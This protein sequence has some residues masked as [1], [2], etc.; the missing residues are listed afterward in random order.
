MPLPDL[1]NQNIQDTYQRVL[2][3]DASG[4]IRDGT[5]SLYIPPSASHATTASYAV[6]ASHEITYELSSSYAQTASNATNFTAS[7]NISASGH[8]QAATG[9]FNRLQ[10]SF[11]NDDTDFIIANNQNSVSLKMNN[12]ENV[13]FKN[14]E[15]T[16]FQPIT[17][18]GEISA[19][20]VIYG[21]A[22][23][24]K[25]K[26]IGTSDSDRVTLGNAGFPTFIQGNIT[27]S[28][29]ISASDI[30]GRTGSFDYLESDR[31]IG[32][33][34]D[35][36]TGIQFAPDTTII[37]SNN[38]QV[39]K[40]RA[41]DGTIIGNKDYST[42][43]SGSTF[44]VNSAQQTFIGNLTSSGHLL[45]KDPDTQGGDG[46]AILRTTGD[47]NAGT[48]IIQLGD[49]E[50]NG[51]NTMVSIDDA[52]NKV[53]V[54]NN[55]SAS[56][57]ITGEGLVISDDANI[58][59]NLTV[60]GNITSSGNISASS[61]ITDG[62]ITASRNIS[63][64]GF[65]AGNSFR[66]NGRIYT[67]YNL[68]DEHF[69][70]NTT[71]H[72]P[73][74]SAVGGFHTTGHLTASGAISSSAASTSSFGAIQMNDNKSIFF[75]NAQDLA[76]YHDGANSY[77][78]ESGTGRLHLQGGGG[79]DIIS[80]ADE[81]MGLFNANGSVELY[82]DNSKKFETTTGGIDITGN[83]TASG[84]ITGSNTGSFSHVRAHGG[85]SLDDGK[86]I[87][88]ANSPNTKIYLSNDD[89]WIITGNGVNVAQFGNGELC[90]NEGGHTTD[91]RVE[92]DNDQYQI[93]SDGGTEKVG[94]GTPTPQEK[95]TV[96]G[97]ISASGAI[98]TLSH[99]TASGVISASGNIFGGEK[100]YTNN[101]EALYATSATN[102]S[103]GWGYQHPNDTIDIGRNSG[104]V[105]ITLNG[106][107]SASGNI[108]SLGNI[109]SSG[110]I[111]ASFPDT[112]VDALHYP[113]V[114][115]ATKGV[116][117]TQNSLNINPA[118]STLSVANTV[119][120]SLGLHTH[121]F[122]GNITASGHISS[123]GNYIGRREFR[124]PN[125]AVDNTLAQGDIVYFG[126]EG[127]IAAGDIV[128]MKDD[129]TW[130]KSDAD[131]VAR[132]T[133]LHG[134]ALGADASVH[135]VLLRGTY[136][137]DHDLGNGNTGGPLYLSGT[138]G[139]LTATAP[140][141][142]VVRVM[143]YQLGDEDEIWFCPD[144]T[145]VELS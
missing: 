100:L 11:N 69:I 106:N 92:S 70:R 97:N 15:T 145:W 95:F 43:I 39:A 142:G 114:T 52:Q 138:E 32:H 60:G 93:F 42:S 122:T 123:S 67:N 71:V 77:I 38:V 128:Y 26:M 1:T 88:A 12:I 56:G 94:I 31:I 35:A 20:D 48:F 36:N 8:I 33:T 6:S 81:S 59:D 87:H 62:H 113:L 136:T 44:E 10:L 50:A 125:E 13:N 82:H 75:G 66:G 17:A 134:I 135:G 41:T 21:G 139:Q 46:G 108:T 53:V 143:G 45:F 68:S 57:V 137:L 98:N 63:A 133:R 9:S 96:H 14:N 80:P 3:R 140:S 83:I 22:F 90:V 74:V 110:H 130:N 64:S 73:I 127:S 54:T 86:G 5:G 115:A 107:I 7:G 61:F 91:F 105:P 28:G 37:N 129:G 111:S 118:T 27:G 4:D 141:S 16:F 144:N 47:T 29:N 65:I 102:I 72:N 109:S 25:G 30:T 34:G 76:V 131:V 116:I 2:Q 78:K 99:I 84:N 119:F 55:F 49:I 103:L 101:R 117:Q 126:N 85:I 23:V 51:G 121:T 24:S 89:Y 132:A 120:G 40:F 58:T 18:S 19:S 104:D 124:M 112:N 79:I